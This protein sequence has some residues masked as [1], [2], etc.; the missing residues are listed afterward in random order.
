M[1]TL[2]VTP[3]PDAAPRRSGGT[4]LVVGYLA[5][6]AMLPYLLLKLAWV[7]GAT[8]GLADAGKADDA[9][10]LGLNA[11]TL[12]MD[13]VAVVAVLAFTHSWG[14]RAPA[15][16]VLLP[17]WVATGLLVPFAFRAPLVAVAVLWNA[18][19]SGGSASLPF[20]Q[21]WVTPVVY[22]SFTAQGVGITVAFWLYARARWARVFSVR[23]GGRRTGATHPVHVFAAWLAAALTALVA[24]IQLL[25]ATGS[26][27]GLPE[28]LVAGAGPSHYLSNLSAGLFAAAGAVGL[29]ALVRQWGPGTPY[30]VPLVATWAGA[31]A[32]WAWG[33]W[34]M[35][36]LLSG[37]GEA[38]PGGN[39]LLN[40]VDLVQMIAGMLIAT[41]GLLV[42]AETLE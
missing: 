6:A 23:A 19:G 34:G 40:W 14:L 30:W 35:L 24:G 36:L 18:G 12:G 27:L 26:D 4:R 10:L 21:S 31:G 37:A 41:I 25:W 20:L 39:G 32:M 17:V 28:E 15:W 1:H 2:S 11:L 8:I 3:T 5:I 7:S 16:S 42:T 9:T 13:L 22:T 29:L 33:A 38:T